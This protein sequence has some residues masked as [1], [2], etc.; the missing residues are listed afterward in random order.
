MNTLEDVFGRT[1]TMNVLNLLSSQFPEHSTEL[2]K[3]TP[4]FILAC[5]E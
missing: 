2:S 1:K 5:T 3:L 4:P